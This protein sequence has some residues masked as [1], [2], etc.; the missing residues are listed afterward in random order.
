MSD[1]AISRV[2]HFVEDKIMPRI[3]LEATDT[4]TLAKK[5]DTLAFGPPNQ[6]DDLSWSIDAPFPGIYF[7]YLIKATGG[8]LLTSDTLH[9]R[10]VNLDHP[11]VEIGKNDKEDFI[12]HLNDIA[13]A[14]R[15]AP[16]TLD[17]LSHEK[18]DKSYAILFLSDNFINNNDPGKRLV[19]ARGGPKYPPVSLSELK[20]E[21]V[22][23]K[24]KLQNAHNIAFALKSRKKSFSQED[25]QQLLNELAP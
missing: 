17:G 19:A 13:D 15:H 7:P 9:F 11:D 1:A 3:N 8:D 4:A 25:I 21:V 23:L 12:V 14:Y 22:T 16:S 24:A 20:R 18:N 2:N 10:G 5:K 6:G